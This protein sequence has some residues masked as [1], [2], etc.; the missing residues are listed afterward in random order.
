[1]ISRLIFISLMFFNFSA[2]SAEIKALR[3]GQHPDKVRV[4]FD[5]NGEMDFSG[6]DC[7]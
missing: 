2:F 5:M 4:V 6:Q 7:G 1:M 3:I